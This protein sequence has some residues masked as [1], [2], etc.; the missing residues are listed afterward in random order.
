MTNPDQDLNSFVQFLPEAFIESREI[1]HRKDNTSWITTTIN[2][3]LKDNIKSNSEI[4]QPYLKYRFRDQNSQIKT[5][6]RLKEL[7]TYTYEMDTQN[8]HWIEY[9]IDRLS[10]DNQNDSRNF[11]TPRK[12]VKFN[13]IASETSTPIPTSNSFSAL[14]DTT[15]QINETNSFTAS[16]YKDKLPSVYLPYPNKDRTMLDTLKNTISKETKFELKGDLGGHAT[17][18]PLPIYF[19]L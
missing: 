7:R 10:P 4:F 3:D 1:S 11:E 8:P 15:Q 2:F 14:D 12:T 16:T 13:Q 6:Y 18:P 19:S 17:G 5:M 9:L